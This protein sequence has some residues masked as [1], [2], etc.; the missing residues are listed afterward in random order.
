[1]ELLDD[2]SQTSP[3]MADLQIKDALRYAETIDPDDHLRM[4]V[5]WL[6]WAGVLMVRRRA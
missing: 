4:Q 1:M 3:E 2:S 6:E 5:K